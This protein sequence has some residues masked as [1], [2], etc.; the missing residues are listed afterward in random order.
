[1]LI[2]AGVRG[3][4]HSSF[5]GRPSRECCASSQPPVAP[6]GSLF[7]SERVRAVLG[8]LSRSWVCKASVTVIIQMTKIWSLRCQGDF[9]VRF[10]S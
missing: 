7:G 10:F 2:F 9:R 5:V 1:M 3:A 8:A 4:R 6:W